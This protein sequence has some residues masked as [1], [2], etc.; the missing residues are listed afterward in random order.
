MKLFNRLLKPPAVP[1]SPPDDDIP[2]YPPFA[3]GLPA[4]PVERILATQS[5]LI[6]ALRQT[7]ALP[8]PAFR[9]I[10]APVL[11]RYA[12][13]THLLPA[14]EAHHHRGAG[15]LFRHGLEVAYWAALASEGALFG[16]GGTPRERKEQEPRWRLAVGL[17]GLLHD[18]GKPV[19]D[20]SVIDREGTTPWNPYLENLTD[21]AA[22]HRID[23]YFL[24][25][26]DKRH[27]RHEQFSVL[28]SERVLTAGCLSYLTDPGP[29]ILQAMLEAIAGVDRGGLL[30]GFVVEADRK[31]VERDLKAHHVPLEAA[32]GVP[33]DKYLL[34]AMRRLVR[35]GRWTVNQRGARLWRFS[36]GLHVVWKAA[37]GDI[38]ELLA[39]DHIPGIPRDPDTLADILLERGLAIPRENPDGRPH[40]YWR[41]IPAEL[42]VPLYMLRLA[43]P[44]LIFSGE[45][46]LIVDGRLADDGDSARGPSPKE[47]QRSGVDESAAVAASG[48]VPVSESTAEPPVAR[49]PPAQVPVAARSR[50]P[51]PA[52][53][54]APSRTPPA[55]MPP[56]CV[57]HPERLVTDGIDVPVETA[58]TLPPLSPKSA[59]AAVSD[60][61]PPANRARDEARTWLSAQGAAGELLA[62][63]IDLANADPAVGVRRQDPGL[64]L[65]HPETAQ[66]LGRHPGKVL[67]LLDHAGW[68]ETDMRTPLLKIRD[69]DGERGLLLTRAVSQKAFALLDRAEGPECEVRPAKGSA[70]A[71]Q[72]PAP[73]PT[74]AVK[75]VK[76]GALTAHSPPRRDPAFGDPALDFVA[77]IRSGVGLP[78]PL[79]AEDGWLVVPEPIV[80][81]YVATRPGLT[82]TALKI[83]LKRL[84]ECQVVRGSALKIR[85]E[86]AA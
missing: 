13:F 28:V 77:V 60:P 45:P 6:D 85:Q 15:G 22:Q 62:A 41:M 65:P 67:N 3:K 75:P 82:S 40:R 18:I 46:P 42:D 10:L 84:P 61:L 52:K 55:E 34:D 24:R 21:W 59:S 50:S 17:A 14:S 12:A 64:W 26:R 38:G 33:V 30:A 72:T 66:R 23:R 27:Q 1:P 8:E 32:L 53:T 63:V 20:L 48:D 56:P 44:E 80:A 69:F 35:E 58:S 49:V 68:I 47:I 31:S 73:T 25:W 57:E 74:Q 4:A 36:D 79:T 7:L 39:R 76:P 9:S 83:H 78:E 54:G 86:A 37:A 70:H 71:T 16:L 11:E 81:W 43:M 51:K 19:S 5:D 2:R 29:E